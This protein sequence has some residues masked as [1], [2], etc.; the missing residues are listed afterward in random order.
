MLVKIYLHL[1][2]VKEQFIN[3]VNLHGKDVSHKTWFELCDMKAF[4]ISWFDRFN[5]SKY[6]MR[7]K[8]ESYWKAKNFNQK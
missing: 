4:Q 8:A 5:R 2:L 3:S 6:G 7:S 1:A